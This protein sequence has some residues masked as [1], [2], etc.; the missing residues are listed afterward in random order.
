M[1]LGKKQ[2]TVHRTSPEFIS[3]KELLLMELKS[4]TLPHLAVSMEP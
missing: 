2:F 4:V 3:D 1:I